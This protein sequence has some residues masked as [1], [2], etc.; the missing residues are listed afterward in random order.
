M[1]VLFC[2]L[3]AGVVLFLA[4]HDWVHLPPFTDI[5][6]LEKHHSV[7]DRLVTTF[8]T[9]ARKPHGLSSMGMNGIRCSSVALS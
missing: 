8:I 3:Q 7:N 4:L 6:A 5:R 1:L 9:H 2:L